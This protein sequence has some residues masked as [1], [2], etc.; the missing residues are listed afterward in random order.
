MHAS[1]LLLE[2]A[3]DVPVHMFPKTCGWGNW[4][5]SLLES[6]KRRS[7]DALGLVI[8]ERASR[9]CLGVLYTSLQQRGIEYFWYGVVTTVAMLT[10]L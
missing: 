6:G 7:S 8:A 3:Y 2:A 1:R 10:W 9:L 5:P 4:G